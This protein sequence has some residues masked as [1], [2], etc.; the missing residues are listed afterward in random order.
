[1]K[2]NL[3][4]GAKQWILLLC[5]MMLAGACQT[6]DALPTLIDRDATLNAFSMEQTANAPVV[7]PTRVIPT[8]PPTFTPTVEI[9]ASN[10]PSPTRDPSFTDTPENYSADGTLYYI[11]NGDSIAR[12]LP[13]GSVNEIVVTFGVDKP[14][15]DLNISPKGDLLTFVAPGNGSA[16]EVYVASRDGTYIQQVSCLGFADVQHP[17]F[18]PSGERI[19]FFAGELST[20]NKGLYI[21]NFAGSNNCPAG[22][23]QR[24]LVALDRVDVGDITWNP[25]GTLIF[26]SSGG[27]S[28]YQLTTNIFAPLTGDSGLGSDKSLEFSAETNQLAHLRPLQDFTTGKQ[29]GALVVIENA[30]QL[31]QALSLVDPLGIFANSLEWASDNKN[32]LYTTDTE[33]NLFDVDNSSRYTLLGDLPAPPLAIFDPTTEKLAYTTPHSETGVT[34]V[35]VQSRYGGDARQIT[36]NPEGTITD[37]IWVEG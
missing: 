27:T 7:T 15:R 29:G 10:T 1:M 36:S 25:E 8:F 26:Y 9:L 24:L 28:V 32:M 37:L 11:Y 13:D 17:T 5:M 12:L 3:M 21:A 22:N 18:S 2:E 14:I 20:S 31:P 4:I 23:S 33:I 16:L 35:F 34:Q 30:N 19:A 6:D